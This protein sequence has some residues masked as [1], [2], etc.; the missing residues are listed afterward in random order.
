MAALILVAIVFFAFKR[1][2]LQASIQS[3][4]HRASNY[5]P[6]DPV[7][8]QIAA[9]HK[10]PE[11]KTGNDLVNWI[12]F[13]EAYKQCKVNPRPIIVDVYTTWCG[14]CKMMSA[15]TFNQPQIAE[16][17]NKN[18]YAVKFDAESK[19]SVLFDKYVFVSSDASNPKSPHQFAMSILDNQ[20]AYPSIVFLNNQIQ[21]LDII[22]GFYPPQSF[23]PILKY[24]GSGDYQK[25][26]WEDYKNAFTS[27]LK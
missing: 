6:K 21:R 12:S 24:Y 10:S 26:T 22:K 7:P 4:E 17:I 13:H 23:E 5:L 20:L 1:S 2:S 8:A 16:Y 3:P 18:F 14:P 27:E 25:T 19:D 15:Q 11:T 9:F